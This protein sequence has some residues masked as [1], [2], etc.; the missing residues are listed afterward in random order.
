M[1]RVEV[2][3]RRKTAGLSRILAQCW[4]NSS[5]TRDYSKM[6]GNVFSVG[7]I[8]HDPVVDLMRENQIADLSQQNMMANC[9][10][11]F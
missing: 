3:W 9:V 10:E 5:K 6:S 8:A 4:R 2:R 7:E 1:Q 11:S